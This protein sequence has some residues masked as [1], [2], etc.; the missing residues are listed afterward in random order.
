MRSGGEA[1]LCP[2]CQRKR[3]RGLLGHDFVIECIC[4]ERNS[5]DHPEIQQW[6]GTPEGSV[7]D[8]CHDP[9][10]DRGWVW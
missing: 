7:C 8:D 5:V 4:C 3:D 10:Q 6:W 9:E 2:R 1:H